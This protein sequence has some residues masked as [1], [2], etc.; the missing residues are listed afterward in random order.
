MPKHK[1]TGLFAGL[2]IGALL[3]FSMFYFGYL[4]TPETEPVLDPTD[5]ANGLLDK[6]G[7]RYSA[8]NVTFF[9]VTHLA[10][11]CARAYFD[12]DGDVLGVDI[13]PKDLTLAEQEALE[14]IYPLPVEGRV[15]YYG[16]FPDV[17]PGSDEPSMKDVVLIGSRIIRFVES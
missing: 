3:I 6:F 1:H 17:F 14:G 13:C 4:Q 8:D 11:R 2:L 7:S 15:Y 16:F 5:A 12:V 10:S 9:L